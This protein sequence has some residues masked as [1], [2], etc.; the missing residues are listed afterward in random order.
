ML[1][2]AYRVKVKHWRNWLAVTLAA[3]GAYLAVF[4]SPRREAATPEACAEE[5]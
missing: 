2:L 5:G 3:S 1:R 4:F